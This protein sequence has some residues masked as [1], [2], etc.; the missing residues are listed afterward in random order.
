VD[1]NLNL[2]SNQIKIIENVPEEVYQ[3]F[4]FR[5]NPLEKINKFPIGKILIL[6]NQII[7]L[8]DNELIDYIFNSP[9][10][11][12]EIN[13]KQNPILAIKFLEAKKKK[14]DIENKIVIKQTPKNKI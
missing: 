7:E 13:G 12:V 10:D 14:N 6:D 5:N 4:N 8:L 1:G 2:N 9:L 3:S 11:N